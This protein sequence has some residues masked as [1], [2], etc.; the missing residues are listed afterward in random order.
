MRYA[1]L[2]AFAFLLAC[3]QILFKKAALASSGKSLLLGLLNSWMLVALVV[4]G[5]ATLLWVAILRTTPL[6]VAYPFA[7]LGFVIVPI[8]ARVMFS[9]P[10]DLRYAAGAALI[11]IGILLTAR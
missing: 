8:A 11:V 10:L 5:V 4:Y 1:S 3:G 6:S 9:E 2:I 7:A